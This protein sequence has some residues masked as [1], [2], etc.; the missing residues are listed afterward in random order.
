MIACILE[1]ESNVSEEHTAFI[2]R[3]EM[4]EDSFGLRGQV[5]PYPL[6]AKK[7]TSVALAR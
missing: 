7:K 3:M 2:F 1:V 4:C 5:A 6:P